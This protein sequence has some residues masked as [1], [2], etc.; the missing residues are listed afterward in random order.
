M[1]PRYPLSFCLIALGWT[2]PAPAQE[3]EPPASPLVVPV[4]AER[5]E[6][7][8]VVRDKHE[9]LVRDL[10][11]E[12]VEVREDGV[13]QHL[14][15]FELVDRQAGGDV[16]AT[17]AFLALA[18]DRLGPAA[19]RF[20]HG[21]A[22]EYLSRELSPGSEVGV[23]SIDRGLTVRQSFTDDRE[24]LRRAVDGASSLSP[25]TLAG[26]RERELTRNA[27]HGLGEG[28]GQA[29]VAP[30]EQKGAPECRGREEVRIR[31]T[32]L[33]QSRLIEG[34]ESLERDQRGFGTTHALLAL[35]GALQA[36]P[37]RKAVVLFS[38]GLAVPSDVEG[39]YRAVVAAANRARVSLYTADAEGLRVASPADEMRLAADTL[40]TR[41]RASSDG[42]RLTE[43]S[44]LVLLE[45]NQDTLRLS[46]E[47]TLGQL[48]DQT[49][50][51]AIRGTN[52]LS[53]G[54]A[55]IEEELRTHYVLSY[56]PKNRDFDGRFRTIAV[57]VGRPYGRL[58]ARK[59]YLAVKT[60]L[61]VPVLPYEA[62]A[63]A[64]LD[65]G[66]SPEDVPLRLR[67]LQFP[68]EPSFSR[69]SILV[70]VPAL[71]LASERDEKA[72]VF[73][74]DL[75]IVVL[76]R[77]GSRRVMQK[78]SQHYE[79]SGRLDRSAEAPRGPILFYR[80]V[81]L[82]AGDYTLEAVA[83]DAKAREAG[84]AAAALEVPR[85]APGHLRASSLV[86]VSRAEKLDADEGQPP[87]PLQLHDVLLYP[88]LGQPVTRD[89]GR[90]LAFFLRAWPAAERPGVDARVEVLRGTQTVAAA[91]PVRLRPEADGLVQLV[92]SF[93]VES[94]VPGAYELRVTLTDGRDAE[95]RTTALSVGP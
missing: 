74:Q 46:P 70:E 64:R 25:T 9:K 19:R 2:V 66:A 17:P 94:L 26:K 76:V 37:G 22:L 88:N 47:S 59:G 34:F 77:D 21:A 6:V 44:P 28:F 54:L 23:F 49:G 90:P 14:E 24:A 41:L 56:T 48:A 31:L 16:P 68:E 91:R 29:H 4:G 93:P 71:A 63:L 35:I 11:P 80:E 5:V 30:A 60:P 81:R 43:D 7:D 40:R 62:P 42:G 20:A 58:Q 85:A 82:P 1:R 51:F 33:L 65:R 92:S 87:R 78:L 83:W 53:G 72:G 89:A 79:L 57:R 67:G 55:L 95:M 73:R 15:S 10:R 52:D 86:V 45:R 36:L 61:P 3:A 50:G 84:V 75:V 69:V 32:E 8:L 39:T 27:Y 12:D 13:P 18:F 38:E